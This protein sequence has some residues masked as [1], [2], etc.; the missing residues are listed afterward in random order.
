MAEGMLASGK[1]CK[2]SIL[3]KEDPMAEPITVVVDNE[4]IKFTPG[5]KVAVLDAIASLCPGEDTQAL[6]ERL[7]RQ[8]PELNGLCEDYPFSRRKS[9]LVTDG[10]GWEIIQEAL[11]DYILET[12]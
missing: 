1:V 3:K 12:G 6:W 7:L 10:Q 9:T 2:F 11:F 5:G 4:R 8:Q